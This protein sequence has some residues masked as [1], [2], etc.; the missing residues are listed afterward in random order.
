MDIF[1]HGLWAGAGA[2]AV[3]LKKQT[4]LRVWLAMLFGVFPDLFAFAISFVYRNWARIAGGTQPFVF[5][6]GEMEPPIQNQHPLLQLTHALYDISHSL[7]VFFLVFA[8]VSWYFR[9]PIWEMGGWILHILM[10]IPSHSYAFFPTPFLWP[11]SSFKVNGIPWSAP[12][13]FWT[14][15]ALLATVYVLLWILKKRRTKNDKKNK[16]T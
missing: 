10:D 3:N 12:V 13:F 1:S 5:R 9:R 11:I 14:N 15:I 6:P 16:I 7:F 8:I 2:K 4:P